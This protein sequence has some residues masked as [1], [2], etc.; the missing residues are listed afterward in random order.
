MNYNTSYKVQLLHIYSI[1]LI[2]QTV[3]DIKAT[4]LER[5]NLFRPAGAIVDSSLQ[6]LESVPFR[7]IPHPFL[8]KRTV[9][10]ARAN[11]RPRNPTDIH[12][13]FDESFLSSSFLFADL[14]GVGYR[15]LLF[16][17]EEQL[18]D[19]RC[20]DSWFLDATFYVV[21]APFSQLFTVHSPSGTDRDAVLF[22]RVFVLMSRR[23]TE[24]YVM[25][26]Q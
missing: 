5:E 25:V 3:R 10:R 14:H 23:R 13:D 18:E 17:M 21:R 24:D 19:L 22:P 2:L 15:H 11:T 9:N 7:E 26:F 16:G 4:S 8:L 20:S 6:R 12:F 1:T